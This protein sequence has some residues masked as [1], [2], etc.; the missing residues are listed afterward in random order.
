[1]S[2]S[3]CPVRCDVYQGEGYEDFEPLG[4]ELSDNAWSADNVSMSNICTT[5]IDVSQR[6]L[7]A[8]V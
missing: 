5:A 8:Y 1:M 2:T 3:D 7:E 6:L 4:Q